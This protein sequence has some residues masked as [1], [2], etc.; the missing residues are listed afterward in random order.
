MLGASGATGGAVVEKLCSMPSITRLTLLGRRPVANLAS[1]V[2]AQ[3]IVDPLDASTYER[4]LPG[5][6]CAVCTLG[7]SQPSKMTREEFIRIDKDAVLSFGAQCRSAGIR[8]FELLG[9]ASADARSRFPYLKTKGELRDGLVALEFERL[10]IFQPSMILTPTNR[11]GFSQALTLT[12]WPLLTP[13][14]VGSWRKYRG[15]RVEILGA[16]MAANLVTSG[17]GL[18]ILHWDQFLALAAKS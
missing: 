8:H 15:V 12:F 14:L 3:H 7:V 10:S 16:A 6:D 11:F 5:H 18:E 9:S 13:A 1:S 4:L 2:V 17:Q